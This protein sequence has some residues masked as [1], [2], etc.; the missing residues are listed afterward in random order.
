ML[1]PFDR[2]AQKSRLILFG[3]F[4]AAT[5]LLSLA[6]GQVGRPLATPAAPQGIISFEF[7]GT[8]ARAQEIA[9]SWDAPARLAAAFQLGLDYLFMPLYSTAFAQ[10]CILA[11]GVFRRR[12]PLLASLGVLLA[13]GQWLAAGFDAVENMGLVL[14]LLWGNTTLMGTA[15]VMAALKFGL[16]AAGLLYS[17]AGLIT[18]LAA[19]ERLSEN[20]RRSDF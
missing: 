19:P 8:A 10:A 18:R 17:L 9:A 3:V 20:S 2:L 1:H 12:S 14:A 7:A 4:L 16:L 6:M 15:W 13:W 5:A 11:A